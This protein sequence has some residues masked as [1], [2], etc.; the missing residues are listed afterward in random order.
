M[1]FYEAQLSTGRSNI[2][3][4]TCRKFATIFGPAIVLAVRATPDRILKFFMLRRFY[5]AFSDEDFEEIS[6]KK[7]RAKSRL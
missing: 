6:S 2:S 3:D 4:Y 1:L 5:S 7:S